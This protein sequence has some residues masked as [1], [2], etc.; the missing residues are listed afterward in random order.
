MPASFVEGVLDNV[1]VCAVCDKLAI[2][3]RSSAMTC[4][5]ACRVQAHRTGKIKELAAF[6]HAF[7]DHRNAAL[8]LR[9][10]ALVYLFGDEVDKMVQL[11]KRE[12]VLQAKARWQ[13]EAVQELMRRLKLK[14]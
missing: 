5:P 13:R 4:S 1:F 12:T 6:A 3:G 2:S 14:G 10:R 7:A 9:E 11:R 8:M